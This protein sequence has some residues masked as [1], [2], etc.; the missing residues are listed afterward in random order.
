MPPETGRSRERVCRPITVAHTDTAKPTSSIVTPIVFR[1]LRERGLSAL[2][3]VVRITAPSAGNGPGLRS[4]L[5]GERPVFPWGSFVFFS[6]PDG[7]GWS[8]QQMPA[9]D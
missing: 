1:S 5:W 4:R 8:A 7:N 6:D 9:R 3:W 2:R